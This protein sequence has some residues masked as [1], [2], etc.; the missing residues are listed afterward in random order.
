MGL[1][2]LPGSA[3]LSEFRCDQLTDRINKK[4]ASESAPEG[5]KSFA[6][7]VGKSYAKSQ[8][9]GAGAVARVG[10]YFVHL[11]Q[12]TDKFDA[13]SKEGKETVETLRMLLRYGTIESNTVHPDDE[14][15]LASVVSQE[16]NNK[17]VLVVPRTGTISPWSS[18]A[19]DIA[20]ICGLGHHVS[21]VE[22]ATVYA[23][24]C[25]DPAAQTHVLDAVSGLVHD[26]MTQ[27]IL[28][29][30][31]AFNASTQ[32]R[33]IKTVPLVQASKNG[34]EG[35]ATDVLIKANKEWGLAL[36]QEEISYLVKAFLGEQLG[37]DPTD[38]ELMMFGQVNSEHCR[39]KIF[40][41]A[42]TIDNQEK[43]H[44]LFDMI[45]NT[46]K[47][48]PSRIISAYSDNAAV[49]NG[50]ESSRFAASWDSKGEYV[51]SKETVHTLAKVETHNHPT[52][53]SPFPGAATG[54][55][56]EIRDEG[57]VGQGSK[58][59]TGLTGFT[60]SNLRIPGFVQPW[61][62]NDYG[63]PAHIA[64]AY[65]IMIEGPLG[66]AAFNNEFGRPNICGYFRTFE[67]SANGEMRGYLKPI[68]IAGGTGSVR[69]MHVF[70]K[71]IPAGS[72]IIVLGGPSML[73]GLGGGAA[74]SMTSGTSSIDLDFA[75]VQRDNPEMQRRA[76][77][78]LD[79]CTNLG[80]SSPLLAVHDVGAGGLCNGLP[81][82]VYDSHRGAVFDIRAVPC[83]D[84]SMSPMEIWCNESQERYVLA[85]AAESK[86]QFENIC[87]RE[88]CPFAV[89]GHATA[90]E[91]LIVKDSLL[92]KD[93]VNLSMDT[94]F[95]NAPRM[96]RTAETK[97]F[98]GEAFRLP[99]GVV[100]L[101][102]IV[103]RVLRFP[104][105]A[106]KSFLITI[107][108]RTVTGLVGRDQMVGPWQVPVAD[109][110][111]S[112]TGYSDMTGEAM[113]M[114]ERTPLALISPAASARMA[115]AEALTNILAANVKSLG[116]IRLSANWM[117]SADHPGE[118]SALY[119]GVFAVGMDMCPKLGVTI[120]VGKDSMSMKTRWTDPTTNEAKAVTAP[121]SLII[122]AY[123]P[124]ENT[125]ETLTPELRQVGEDTALVFVDLGYGKQRMGG[126]SLAQVYNVFGNE[127]P[128]FEDAE[129]FKA[130]WKSMI[131]LNEKGNVVLAYHDRSDGGL[132]TTVAEMAFAG[133]LGVD[134][135]VTA[136]GSDYIASLFNEEL[137]VVVQVRKADVELFK[138][139]LASNGFPAAHVHT[140]G[141]VGS[142]H[143]TSVTVRHGGKSIFKE[144]RVSLQRAWAETSYRMQSLRDDPVSAQQEYNSLLDARDPGLQA[145]LTFN[146]SEVPMQIHFP[147]SQNKPKVAILREQGINSF[148][149]MAWAFHTAGF[150]CVDVHMTDVIEARVSL[151]GFSGLACPGGFSY[152][153]VLGAGAGW[154]KSILLNGNAR[155][156]LSTFFERKDTFTIGICNG[157]QMLAG[158]KSIIPGA[159]GWPVFVR[160]K[161]EQFEARVATLEV[162][163][164][165]TLSKVFFDGMEGSRIP[166]AVAHG[167]GRAQFVSDAERDAAVSGGANG[168]LALRYVDNYGAPAGPEKYPLNPN[169]SP[170]GLAG[171]VSVGDGGKVLAMMPHPE[172]VIRGVANTWATPG[173]DRAG[174]EHSG[175]IRMFRN[176]R[177]WVERQQ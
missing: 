33:T 31:P 66:G 58:P 152:G 111:V 14:S 23:V 15:I 26:R 118:G 45:R 143:S 83:D 74:S 128:D 99:A 3:A 120:P 76:Q 96:Y 2:V 68:M 67:A 71:E 97:K 112:L 149:E 122:T 48:N 140:V 8:A 37:R 90:E 27:S 105:V 43:P 163:G 57:A 16:K 165:E 77:M 175:W 24:H 51:L 130:F 126:S 171:V 28:S 11:V 100:G 93:V 131:A 1:L 47:L 10:A 30:V 53:V 170:F 154:A 142:K 19:S 172:R 89:V 18:K 63:K 162:V 55:G 104:A 79:A 155:R 133:H 166:I 5:G 36:A 138:S 42:W 102:E 106:S 147:L 141:T 44:S 21:R 176:A 80:D 132:F 25:V 38:A 41:A 39:H 50:P 115:V 65:D 88:R 91:R 4:L 78:V 119:E 95:G 52:A 129:A 124:V 12:T 164:G 153:D 17:A 177:L 56:G 117:S 148:G 151:A 60:V 85:I 72:L 84:P 75:S 73:I 49:L 94:L 59:R 145:H 92:G 150:T 82:L 107:G 144:S 127:A 168:C 54:S 161:S 121:L 7:N 134:L 22:R 64:S 29:V 108:D 20:R 174:G 32:P 136:L 62:T 34:G 137:G 61:E 13:A 167:E 114:G 135:D 101:D 113:S 139:T 103:G 158:L 156:E 70:K 173:L 110:A 125:S 46:Y 159:S 169:G 81:E 98:V 146:S 109:V 9:N 87:A 40:K 157:C 116:D 69:P 6:K 86:T 35:A 160:N 123:G